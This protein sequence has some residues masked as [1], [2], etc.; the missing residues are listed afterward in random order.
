MVPV[1]LILVPVTESHRKILITKEKDNNMI[2]YTLI[3][4]ENG[5]W[6]PQF[7]S[8][9]KD[10]VKYERQVWLD[11]EY[12]AFNVKII[13]TVTEEKDGSRYQDSLDKRLDELNNKTAWVDALNKVLNN[14]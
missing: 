5:N 6:Y 1:Y 4:F 2:Y 8:Y 14:K 9:D 3:V 7:G 10:E 13:K 11:D 12:S